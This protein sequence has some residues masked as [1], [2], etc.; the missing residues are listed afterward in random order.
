MGFKN[1]NRDCSNYDIEMDLSSNIT[2]DSSGHIKTSLRSWKRLLR[3]S[4]SISSSEDNEKPLLHIRIKCPNSESS[5]LE[6]PIHKKLAIES[7]QPFFEGTAKILSL[8]YRRLGI[9]EAV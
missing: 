1:S 9:L 5:S 8:N 3:N 4:N 2:E 6:S 7:D